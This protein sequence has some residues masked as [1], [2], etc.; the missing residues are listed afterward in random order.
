MYVDLNE[1]LENLLYRL[2]GLSLFQFLL[3]LI[4][5]GSKAS[6][7]WSTLM[8]S[9]GGADPE[10]TCTWKTENGFSVRMNESIYNKCNFESNFSSVR[11]ESRQYDGSMHTTVNEVSRSYL[12]GISSFYK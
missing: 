9:F 6:V 4:V 3:T 8:M 1:Y 10:W 5:Y 2:S 11:C 12:F 7:A